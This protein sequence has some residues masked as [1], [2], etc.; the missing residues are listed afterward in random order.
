[1]KFNELFNKIWIHGLVHLFGHKHY[2]NSDFSIM[3][4]VE[5]KY[6]EFINQM[7]EKVLNNR[8]IILY[9]LPFFLGAAS[10]FSFQPFNLSIINFIILPI[11]FLLLVYVKK[12]SKSTYRKKPYRKNLFLLGFIFESLV[13]AF[14]LAMREKVKV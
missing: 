1:M 3:K 7:L 12:R 11:F 5:K 8:I 6:F 10:V 4:K 14:A 9:L 13:Q 2:K